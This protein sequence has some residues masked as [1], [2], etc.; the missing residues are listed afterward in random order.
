ML[1]VGY[2][3]RVKLEGIPD[4]VTHSCLNDAVETWG[5]LVFDLGEGFRGALGQSKGQG[6]DLKEHVGVVGADLI[7]FDSFLDEMRQDLA[8]SACEWHNI[9]LAKLNHSQQAP[10]CIQVLILIEQLANILQ[11][12]ACQ[13]RVHV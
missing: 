1:G 8:E 6:G 9:L 13:L 2:E 10:H 11:Q 3:C 5:Q 12:F 7:I 4:E